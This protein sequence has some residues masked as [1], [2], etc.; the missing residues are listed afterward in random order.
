MVGDRFQI[1]R[2]MIHVVAVAGLGRATMSAPIRRDHPI[3]F[4]E[5]E[6]HLRIPIVR[7]KRPAMAKHDR[8]SAAPILIVDL[9]SVLG[10][11]VAHIFSSLLMFIRVCHA[12]NSYETK[13]GPWFHSFK[14]RFV[15]C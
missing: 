4:G 1:V 11:D 2:I 9:Y 12:L 8:L 15:S 5:E 10:C 14:D 3:T 7:R 13:C 6:Q